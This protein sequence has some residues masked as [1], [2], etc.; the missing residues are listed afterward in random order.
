MRVERSYLKKEE[1]IREQ[2]RKYEFLLQEEKDKFSKTEA[3][4]KALTTNNEQAI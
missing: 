1:S 4:L 2:M 3:A